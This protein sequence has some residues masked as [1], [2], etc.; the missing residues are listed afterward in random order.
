MYALITNVLKDKRLNS[1]G[2]T[3]QVPLKMIIRDI[4][5]LT[6]KETKYA[7]NALTHVDFVIFDT[8]DKSPRLVV[9]VDG[10]KYHQEGTRQSERDV[11]KN[12]IFNKYGLPIL[13]FRTDGSYERKQLIK[14][15]DG[16]SG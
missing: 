12:E 3:V 2:V 1:F 13:R 9:E 7:M 4:S 14:A 8:I 10:A 15:L 16:L 11:M 6:P 5:Q